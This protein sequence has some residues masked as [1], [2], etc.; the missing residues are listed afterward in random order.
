MSRTSKSE[1][2][3]QSNGPVCTSPDLLTVYV[4][5]ILVICADDNRAAGGRCNTGHRNILTGR[6]VTDRCASTGP[7]I[8]FVQIHCEL[9]RDKEEGGPGKEGVC[10][11][12]V[13]AVANL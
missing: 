12:A 5:R 9:E 2:V 13:L 1:C 11:G 3:A 10:Q 4:K 8:S 7:L 6:A